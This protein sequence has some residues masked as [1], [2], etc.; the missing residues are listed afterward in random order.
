MQTRRIC[1][2][3]PVITT[4]MA[5]HIDQAHMPW[6]VG[7]GPANKTADRGRSL[8]NIVIITP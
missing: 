4:H 3:G 2:C 6:Y 5:R 1:V 8:P 7:V